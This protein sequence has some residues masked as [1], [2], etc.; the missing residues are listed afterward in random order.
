MRAMDTMA[1]PF[2]AHPV[3]PWLGLYVLGLVAN[4]VGH[5]VLEPAA[6]VAAALLLVA[7]A[8]VAVVGL[9]ALVRGSRAQRGL[10][11]CALLGGGAVLA[12]QA[13][14]IVSDAADVDNSI[15]GLPLV[16]LAGGIL[17]VVSAGLTREAVR[18]TA[19]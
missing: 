1:R 5:F 14:S 13:W 15:G 11:W 17:M 3:A 8:V 19:T 16:F 9:V 12:I 18:G 4:A 7:P 2:R 10:Q 6:F